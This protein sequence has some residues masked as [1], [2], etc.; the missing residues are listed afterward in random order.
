MM[1]LKKR[2]LLLIVAAALAA[3]GMY[4]GTRP[5]EKVIPKDAA[6]RVTVKRHDLTVEV[7]DTGKVE[8]QEQIE[9]KSKVAGQVLEV[10]IDEGALVKKGQ[11][12]LEL[13]PID[14]QRDVARAQ[15][16]VSQAK[17]ALEYAQLNHDR[18][19]RG[20]QDRGVAQIDVDFAANE[21]KAKSVA[22]EGAQIALE[23]ARDRLRYTRVVSPIDGTVLELGIE[24]GE[25][26][27]PGVQQTFEGRPLLTVG[28]LSTLIVRCELNQIDVAR[29]ALGQKATLTFDALPGKT[30]AAKVTKSAPAAVKAKGKEIEVFPVEAT[31]IESD[32]SIKPGMTADVRFEIEVRPSVFA[33][34]IEAV[35]KE[36]G[37]S[38]VHR[39]TGEGDQETTVKTEVQ[40]GARNEREI[41]ITSGIE[42]GQLLLIDPASSKENEV[43]L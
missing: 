42:E 19:K 43:E 21:V 9:V 35:V 33:V 11:L 22:V 17:I 31:L 28:D 6:L 12:L 39:I 16:E 30:F 1:K 38:Y 2:W 13:D 15:A 29:I 20:L 8:P 41:E 18:K 4:A 40:V 25:V 10:P 27:T 23:T 7:I 34:P 14:Y 5:E 37:K 32:G 36:E 24:K 3:A 26:V